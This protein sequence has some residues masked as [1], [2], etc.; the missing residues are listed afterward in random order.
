M[1]GRVKDSPF[2]RRTF[3]RRTLRRRTGLPPPPIPPPPM[4]PPL[5]PPPHRP[6]PPMPP[7][8]LPSA[9]A[10]PRA[11]LTMIT[12]AA[13]REVIMMP[14]WYSTL[15]FDF[16]YICC[17]STPWWSCCLWSSSLIANTMV[18]LF[19]CLGRS[20]AVMGTRPKHPKL[21]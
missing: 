21:G 7:P 15:I 12:H 3:R 16:I 2:R 18:W 20:S 19:Q 11:P 8:H 1:Y 9:A 17:G 4:P 5:R 10:H 13:R 14:V 6:L